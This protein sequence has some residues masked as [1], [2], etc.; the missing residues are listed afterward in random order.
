MRYESDQRSLHAPVNVLT[1]FYREE[2]IRHRECL[3]HQRDIYSERAISGFDEALR[4]I[5]K[6]LDQLCAKKDV[7][8]VIGRLLRKFD[9]LTGLSA[10]STW[11]DHPPRFH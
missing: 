11:S 3:E 2:F 10:Y 8:V 5:L 4:L 1:A 6:R 7:D 9:V